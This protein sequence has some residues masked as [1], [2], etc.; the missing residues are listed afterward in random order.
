[1]KYDIP[2]WL[3]IGYA[4]LCQR[5]DPIEIEEAKKLGIETMVLLAKARESIRNSSVVDSLDAMRPIMPIPKPPSILDSWAKPAVLN[6]MLNN[7]SFDTSLVERIVENI[8]WPVPPA[9]PAPEL[10]RAMTPKPDD[11]SPI[12]TEIDVSLRIETSSS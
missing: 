11:R 2:Q 7:H 5:Q 8:F 4:A 9:I 1:M 10:P 3:P 6:P 12:E